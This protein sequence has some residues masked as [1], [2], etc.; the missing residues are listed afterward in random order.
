MKPVFTVNISI[1]RSVPN[2][3]TMWLASPLFVFHANH[4]KTNAIMP[5]F[6]RIKKHFVTISI[7]LTGIDIALI[8]VNRIPLQISNIPRVILEYVTTT[9]IAAVSLCI[10]V[11]VATILAEPP[12]Q[13]SS[14]KIAAIVIYVVL[15]VATLVFVLWSHHP[16][17]S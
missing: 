13:L 14:K 15:V 10:T 5:T 3:F 12:F 9:L 6:Q 7:V 17:T 16:I 4:R 11:T 2:L 8:A 1:L